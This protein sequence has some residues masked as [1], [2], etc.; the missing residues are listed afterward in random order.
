MNYKA[1]LT[2]IIIATATTFAMCSVTV[3]QESECAERLRECFTLSESARDTC[4]Q[5]TA[6]L[7]ACRNTSEGRL[8]AKRGTYSTFLTPEALNDGSELPDRVVFDSE[9]VENFDNLWLSHLVN[10]DHSLATCESL[11]ETLEA[12]TAQPAPEMWRP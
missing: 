10:S 3:A 12:C 1:T 4:F 5:S 2:S 6:R 8:A 9:C 11:S 7:S